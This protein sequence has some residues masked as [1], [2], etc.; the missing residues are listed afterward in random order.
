MKTRVSIT[1]S[2][3]LI[4]TS[5]VTGRESGSHKKGERERKRDWQT[6]TESKNY[7]TITQVNSLEEQLQILTAKLQSKDRAY[8][9]V[10]EKLNQ[11][12]NTTLDKII[13]IQMNQRLKDDHTQLREAYDDV[14][15]KAD[16]GREQ[17][18]REMEEI[19]QK[20][21]DERRLLEEE[22]R[23]M[24][25]KGKEES[26]KLI[27]SLREEVSTLK[28]RLEY[29]ENEHSD[30]QAKMKQEFEDRYQRLQRS[31]SSNHNVD[32]YKRKLAAQKF[33]SGMMIRDGFD[34]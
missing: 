11:T 32:M 4:D 33:I 23:L 27:S 10:C 14:V 25:E 7:T 8:K 3:Q 5:V 24:M 18:E 22:G 29:Q 15:R 16:E 21:E 13:S 30:T 31:I 12:E 6:E 19:K 9:D 26:D 28:T 17:L 2:V 20:C 1:R 34:V